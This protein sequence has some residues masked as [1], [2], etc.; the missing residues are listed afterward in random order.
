MSKRAAK[1]TTEQQQKR[2]RKRKKM[3]E[4][5]LTRAVTHIRLL[6]AN[7]GKLADLDALMAVYLP[8]CQQY[9][10]LFCTQEADPDKYTD[11]IFETSLSERLHRVAMQQAAGIATSW[12]TNRTSANHAYL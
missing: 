8:L 3:T 5:T 2:K 12:R 1:A 9:T 6:E 7:P 11:P 4:H 10:T